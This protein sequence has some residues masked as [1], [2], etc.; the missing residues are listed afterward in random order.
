MKVKF[1]DAIWAGF[2]QGIDGVVIICDPQRRN[3]LAFAIADA[4]AAQELSAQIATAA[5]R[6]RLL[7]T[8]ANRRPI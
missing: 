4:D 7:N 5:T 1:P 8:P 3:E 6:L 2:I